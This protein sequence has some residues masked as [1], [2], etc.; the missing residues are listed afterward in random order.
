[1]SIDRLVGD[2]LG[3]I[4]FPATPALRLGKASRTPSQ[5]PLTLEGGRHAII[6]LF[7]CNGTY[8]RWAGGDGQT[9]IE[10]PRSFPCGI[11]SRARA[12]IPT[13]LREADTFW[14]SI[15]FAT[16]N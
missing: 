4:I 12:L 13:I 1:M 5:H 16:I 14:A 6:P 3:R 11:R 15:S 2:P 9:L 10:S 8:L 7:R